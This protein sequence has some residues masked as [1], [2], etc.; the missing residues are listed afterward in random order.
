MKL[1]EVRYN[2]GEEPTQ[3]TYTN[4][5]FGD[6]IYGLA[7]S[8]RCADNVKKNGEWTIEVRNILTKS[9]NFFTFSEGNT[10]N[11]QK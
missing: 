9:V 11:Y 8:K 10:I 3:T 5:T 4:Q 1:A 2:D 7:H 6:I